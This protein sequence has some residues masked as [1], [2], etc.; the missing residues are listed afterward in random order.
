MNPQVIALLL[1][2]ITGHIRTGG[3][4]IGITQEP[5]SGF[6]TVAA[7]PVHELNIYSSCSVVTTAYRSVNR[8]K[9]SS[10]LSLTL[11]CVSLQPFSQGLRG[12]RELQVTDLR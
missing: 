6:L 3:G 5:G 12:A 10:Q 2:V 1:M 9:S 8:W 7:K 4:L 11:S